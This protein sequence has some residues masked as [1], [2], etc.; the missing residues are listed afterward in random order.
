[1][2]EALAEGISRPDAVPSLGAIAMEAVWSVATAIPQTVV[3]DSRWFRPR[4]LE[5]A[6]AA[7][8][9]LRARPWSWGAAISPLLEI[10]LR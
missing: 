4:D 7:V 10:R 9:T 5:F 1:M 8:I 3:I 2:K 6:D